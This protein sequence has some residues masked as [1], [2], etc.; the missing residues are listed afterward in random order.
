MQNRAQERVHHRGTTAK[1]WACCV[2]EHVLPPVA[3]V[4][5]VAAASRA[6]MQQGGPRYVP[7]I[8]QPTPDPTSHVWQFPHG[9]TA[10]D[11]SI[12]FAL[13]LA[14]PK[15]VHSAARVG[16]K[17]AKTMLKQAVLIAF[18]SSAA[19]A[20]HAPNLQVLQR[21]L[22]HS[23]GSQQPARKN[24][25]APPQHTE[26][27]AGPRT[28]H[29]A[30][31]RRRPPRRRRGRRRGRRARTTVTARAPPTSTTRPSRPTSRRS[32]RATRTRARPSCGWPGTR[33]ATTQSRRRTAGQGE[34]RS[35][36][37]RN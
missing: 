21:G 9:P 32:S 18:A 1:A 35:A 34:A 30:G 15:K 22:A 25:H 16:P 13:L 10:S 29:S 24:F 4:R 26:S 5:V 36:S 2:S 23:P 17:P 20:L 19:K 8:N 6:R 3:R 33:R 27:R 31:A 7:H 11:A 12:P 37:R 14:P 28:H